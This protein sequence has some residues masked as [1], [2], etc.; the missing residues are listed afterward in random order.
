MDFGRGSRSEVARELPGDGLLPKARVTT[1]AITIRAR[2]EHVWPWIVQLGYGRAGWYSHDWIDNDGRPSADRIVPEAQ[3]LEVGD[4]I[5]LAPDMGPPVL[6]I[7]PNRFLLAGDRYGGTFCFA[8]FPHD[9]GTRMLSRTRTHWKPS[10]ATLFWI[11]VVD[12][13]AFV[14]E[15]RMLLGL[16]ARAERRPAAPARPPRKPARD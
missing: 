4:R 11:A 7:V 8:L 12:P 10:L 5:L 2:P 6:E 14:M 15:R 3:Q 16:K 9:E 1:R 13:G